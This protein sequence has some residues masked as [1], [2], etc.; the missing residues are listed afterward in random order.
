MEVPDALE[1]RGYYGNGD[2]DYGP[3]LG[4]LHTMSRSFS[5]G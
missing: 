2:D 3:K 5:G 4:F 1:H